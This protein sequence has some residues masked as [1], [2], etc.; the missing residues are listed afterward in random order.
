M[1]VGL[2][3]DIDGMGKFRDNSEE[4]VFL[5]QG[6]PRIV[7]F[8]EKKD[9][10]ATFFVVGNNVK[11]H[12][13]VHKL[14]KK[15][16]IGN[17]SL[18][19]PYFLGLKSFGE[20]KKE[21]LEADKILQEFYGKKIIGFRSPDYS[22]SQSMI[23]IL[24]ENNYRYDSSLI[25]V[26]YPTH[27]LKNYIKNRELKNDKF[28]IK[29]TSFILPFNGTTNIASNFTVMKGLFKFLKSVNKDIILVF[30]DRDFVNK[31]MGFKKFHMSKK[32]FGNRKRAYEKTTRFLDW[33][34]KDNDVL[35][36]KY[37]LQ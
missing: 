2:S 13:N 17:H 36:L 5:E 30:H 33:I 14:L 25:K 24:K 9:A 35:P 32:L 20:Q 18:S 23:K 16:E 3:F 27:Y 10:E 7:E 11:E 34:T 15:Y 28:E 4:D 19:H 26:V 6:I 37:L 31:D 12:K 8:L 22:I 21:I 29:P 1:S